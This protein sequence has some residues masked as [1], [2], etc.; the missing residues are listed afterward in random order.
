[1]AVTSNMS[2]V[3]ATYAANGVVNNWADA[4]GSA[5]VL[6]NAVSAY[7][8]RKLL[9]RSRPKLISMDFGQ[10]RP[11]PAGSGLTIK[12]RK[13]NDLSRGPSSLVLTEGTIGNG[14][15]MSI[16]DILASVKQYGNFITISDVVMYTMDDPVLNEGTDLLSEQLTDT[17]DTLTFATLKA[18]TN[19]RGANSVDVSVNF[20]SLA[21][22]VAST[23]FDY[24]IRQLR[25][26]NADPFTEI[27]RPSTGVASFPIRPAYWAFVHPD[28]AKDLEAINGFI[29]VER[30]ASQ[31]GVHDAEIGSYKNIR[32]LMTTQCPTTDAATNPAASTTW[33]PGTT[34]TN[35]ALVYSTIIV[36]KDAYGLID[37]DKASVTSII[38][39]S[40]PQDTSNPLN[41]YITVGWKM[42]YTS[43]ILDDSKIIR[44]NS[45]A[46]V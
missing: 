17:Y 36:A 15:K 37:L 45:L 31:G 9:E 5:G 6:V 8:D 41:Q 46:S 33:V 39:Q 12:F 35:K 34:N 27:I 23:D 14:E 44:I 2:K 22:A 13:Y 18:G 29:S 32:F 1:M 43:K 19:V 11:L 4:S 3:G 40:G 25:R 30:Y 21:S 28:V 26:N 38:K 42:M 7:Y 16:T 20:G 10:K 24:C